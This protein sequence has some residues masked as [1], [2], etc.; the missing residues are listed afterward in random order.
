MKEVKHVGIFGDSFAEHAPAP[1]WSGQLEQHYGCQVTCYGEGSSSVYYSYNVF[2]ENFHKH[3]L[4]IFLS[5]SPSRYTKSVLTT[6]GKRTYVTAG[7][8]DYLKLN[9]ADKEQ[10]IGYYESMDIDFMRDTASLMLHEVARLDPDVI[11]IPCFPDSITLRSN[12]LFGFTLCDLVELQIK[13]LTNNSNQ[14]WG[15][16][17]INYADN[18]AP[19]LVGHLSAEMSNVVFQAIVNCIENNNYFYE[20]P[21][22]ITMMNFLDYYYTRRENK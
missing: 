2:K 5:T 14:N 11:F 16:F 12:S 18:A 6:D 19:C 9:N 1:H 7:S 15:K 20:I 17:L 8:I 21:K 3:D 4:N 13:L 10:I 22:N